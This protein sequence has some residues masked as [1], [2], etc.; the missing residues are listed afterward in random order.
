[1]LAVTTTG[2]WVIGAVLAGVVVLA[3][4]AL[5][6]AIIG[7]GRRI[8]RQAGE[9]IVALDGTRENTAPLFDVTRANFALDRIARQLRAVREDLEA[10]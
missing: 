2:W 8:V 4:A 3:A 1:V 7:L 6:L 10:R 9:I 5:L